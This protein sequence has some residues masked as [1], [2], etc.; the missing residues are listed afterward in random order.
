V[1][2][3]RAP[4]LL[5]IIQAPITDGGVAVQSG[6]IAAV[7]SFT[8]VRRSW[9]GASVLDH[10][11]AVL[12]PGLINA[13]THLELSCLAHLSQQPASPT[14]TGWLARLIAERAEAATDDAAVKAAARNVLAEQQDQGI[15]AIAD[16]S[17]TGLPGSL[18]ADFKGS[19]LCF[20][21]HLGLRTQAAAAALR[22][23]R[24]ELDAQ[25]CTGHALYSTHPALLHALKARA[26]RLGHIFPIHTAE[27]AAEIE[28]LRTG[29]GEMRDFLEERGFWDGSFQPLGEHGGA[30]TCLHQHGLLDSRT[31]CVHCVHLT[32]EEIA[33]LAAAEAKVCLCPGS[34]AYLGVGTAPAGRLLRQGILPALGTDSLTSNPELSIWREMRL[35]AEAQP[36]LDPAEIVR[37]ATLGGAMAL[38]VEQQLG[39]LEEGKDAAVLCVC[40]PAAFMSAAAVQEYLVH[41]GSQGRCTRCG[42]KTG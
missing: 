12:L 5:P 10:P 6:R 42:A 1:I 18:A 14:F 38:G 39:S 30:V 4:W 19:L 9:P 20:K 26:K 28:L 33:L 11:D 24:D 29:G 8:E 15:V 40:L 17:N 35:L 22:G 16:I 23:L 2:I 21:E 13:H 7:G 25:P 36:S 31:L 41:C 34:N 3:H 27:S 37:M 32:N